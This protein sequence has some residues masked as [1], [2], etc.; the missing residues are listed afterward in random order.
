MWSD[1]NVAIRTGVVS[2]LVALDVDLAKGGPNS[3]RLLVQSHEPLPGTVESL[4]GGGGQH[5]LFQYPG[6]SILNSTAKLGPGIDIRGDGGYI[7]TPPS[8][9]ASGRRYEWDRFCRF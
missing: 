2:G 3:L 6:E 8:L 1:A 5:I 7:I 9:H 4:T